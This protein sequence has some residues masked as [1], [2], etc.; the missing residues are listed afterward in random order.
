VQ[1]E[2]TDNLGEHSDAT[3]QAVQDAIWSERE[4]F[5]AFAHPAVNPITNYVNHFARTDLDVPA[6]PIGAA[7]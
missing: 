1:S 7:E 6:A 5:E 4:P 2:A 3:L